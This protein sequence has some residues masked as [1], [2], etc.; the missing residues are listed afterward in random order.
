MDGKLVDRKTDDSCHKEQ[1]PN[2]GLSQAVVHGSGLASSTFLVNI[3]D[4][5]GKRLNHGIH[6]HKVFG[7]CRQGRF[8]NEG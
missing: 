4:M 5:S 7:S 8:V 1:R 3:N 6:I 2:G